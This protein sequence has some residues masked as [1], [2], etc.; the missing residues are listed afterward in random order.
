MT[1][2]EKVKCY[3]VTLHC[4]KCQLI[5]WFKKYNNST[6][7]NV[8]FAEIGLWKSNGTFYL[9]KYETMP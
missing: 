8:K 7:V 6:K 3:I 1:N 2:D 4:R 9:S 5:M